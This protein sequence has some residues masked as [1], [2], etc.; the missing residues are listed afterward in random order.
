M[1]AKVV[2]ASE[3][4]RLGIRVTQEGGGVRYLEGAKHGLSTSIYE[5]EV[6]P[7]SGPGAH[8]HP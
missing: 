2:R 1:E 8:A 3:M 4:E 5:G 6:L 7:G